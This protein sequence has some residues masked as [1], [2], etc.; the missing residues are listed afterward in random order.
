[1]R[2][3]PGLHAAKA[4]EFGIIPSFRFVI[5]QR[6]VGRHSIQTPARADNR[7]GER[8]GGVMRVSA[9]GVM[10]G[11]RRCGQALA[12]PAARVSLIALLAVLAL[13]A[14]LLPRSSA[15]AASMDASGAVTVSLQRPQ[16]NG[17]VA[18]GP[19]GAN[20][21]VNGSVPAG[22]TVTIGFAPQSAGCQT[23]FQAIPNAQPSVGSDGTF[24]AAFP[25][26]AAT[27]VN[28]EYFI[29]AQDASVTTI[30]QSTDVYRVDAGAPPAIQV[31]SVEN[32][33]A[34]TPAAGTPTPA[35]TATAP[36]GKIYSGAFVQVAGANFTP[37]GQSVLLFL[38]PGRFAPSSYNP[39]SALQV[40]SGDPRT[41]SDGSF[42][43]IVQLPPGESGDLTLSAVSQ[44][45]TAQTLPTLLASQELSIIQ[46]PATPTPLP[47]TSPTVQVTVTPGGSGSNHRAPGPYKITLLIGLGV[48]SVI[49]FIIGVAFLISA[50]SMPKPE[51]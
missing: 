36:D 1:M 30:G 40:V 5:I 16:P 13:A 10:T 39:N 19:V 2:A 4:C 8:T 23:G 38:T 18:E 20:V 6:D 9:T 27:T 7:A 3:V 31:Q 33:N 47:T 26:P 46:A 45:G 11:I 34:P 44:D 29:C 21:F 35:P 37:G 49:L 32:P 28:T 43:V 48:L 22:D 15:R 24:T 50:S 14:W 25:W 12:R 17:G 51:V 41:A 42:T